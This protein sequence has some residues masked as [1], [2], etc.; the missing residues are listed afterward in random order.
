[1][2]YIITGI[3]S[4]GQQAYCDRLFMTC[5]VTAA[6]AAA[7]TAAAAEA[8]AGEASIQPPTAGA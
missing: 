6:A 1:M 4:A 7:T 3:C 8:A 2:A 5:R